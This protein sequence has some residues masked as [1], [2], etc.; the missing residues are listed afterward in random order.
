MY[1]RDLLYTGQIKELV[2]M[3]ENR[4]ILNQGVRKRLFKELSES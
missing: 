2:T 1:G 3:R 4:A